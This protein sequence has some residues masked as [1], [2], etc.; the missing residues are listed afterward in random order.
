MDQFEQ[1]MLTQGVP[2]EAIQKIK[3]SFFLYS[4]FQTKWIYLK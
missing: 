4:L 2:K 1:A 3:Q